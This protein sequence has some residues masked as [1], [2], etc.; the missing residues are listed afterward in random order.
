MKHTNDEEACFLPGTSPAPQ[1]RSASGE[2]D[3]S[4]FNGFGHKV[5]ALRRG[6]GG[7][8]V[9]EING[10]ANKENDHVRSPTPLPSHTSG[11]QI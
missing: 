6:G 8:S 9:S 7:E 10:S 2:D 5:N 3:T 4:A 11:S 1:F